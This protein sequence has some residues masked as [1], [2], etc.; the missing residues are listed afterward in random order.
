MVKY[1][2]EAVRYA[3]LAAHYRQP[4]DWSEKSLMSASKS[5][6]RLYRV[7]DSVAHIESES[8]N[9]ISNR[10]EKALANDLNT[11]DAIASL[12]DIAKEIRAEKSNEKLSSLKSELEAGGELL[13]LFQGTNDEAEVVED[14]R[15][16]VELIELKIKQRENARRDRDFETAD[17][18]RDELLREGISL[19]DGMNGT[20]WFKNEP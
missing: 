5:L 17:N 10:V 12:H 3:L 6:K 16:L 20:E 9:Q 15:E 4:L 14:N 13:G 18:I 8:S 19:K 7:W 1:S 11:S 2:G